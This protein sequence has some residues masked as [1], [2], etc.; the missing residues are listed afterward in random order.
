MAKRKIDNLQ[1]D[2]SASEMEQAIKEFEAQT[3]TSDE[4]EVVETEVAEKTE[5][6]KE[7]TEEPKAEETESA[8]PQKEEVEDKSFDYKKGYEGLRSWNTKLAQEVAETKRRLD[9]INKVR[10]AQAQAQS[11]PRMTQEQ[12]NAWYADDPISASAWIAQTQ[13]EQKVQPL[14][15]RLRDIESNMSEFLAKNLINQF[16]SKYSDFSQLEDEIKEEINALPPGMADN[17]VYYERVLDVA[18][19]TVKGKKL[20]SVIE[21][22]REEG[23]REAMAKSKAKENAYVE[24][25]GKVKS[26]EPL[27]ISGMDA[28]ALFD[29]LKAKGAVK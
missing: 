19:N 10:E 18:Y 24:G 14:Q 9:D 6:V 17:P 2:S 23:R 3:N 12:F 25:S 15:Q 8:A 4:A 28:N 1:P 26:E 21:K 29:L 5:E 13:A 27:D 22:A 11:Q 20:P 16:R 7:K